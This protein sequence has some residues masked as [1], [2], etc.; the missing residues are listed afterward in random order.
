MDISTLG[1]CP[2]FAEALA[3]LGKPGWLPARVVQEDKHA[4]TAVGADGDFAGVIPGRLLH[5]SSSPADLPKVGD[6]VAVSPLPGERKAV[7]EAVL[8]R[9]SKLA[10]KVTGRET[11]EQIV[12]VNVD[13]VFVV[14]ALDASFNLRRL[15][16]F[17]VMV[18]EGGARPV[19]VLNKAD[20]CEQTEKQA[21]EARRAAGGVDL[22]TVSAKTRRGI[23]QLREYLRPGET[24]C[25]VGSSGV[26]KSSL[27]NR[28]H[29]GEAVQATLEVRE[30]DAKG[31]HATTWREIIPLPGGALVVDTPGMREFHLWQVEEGLQGTFPDVAELAL[32]CHFRDCTHEHEQHCAVK[33]AVDSGTLARD[34]YGSFLKLQ[35]E[36]VEVR[37]DETQHVR[38]LQ[39]K[40]DHLSRIKHG[41]EDDDGEE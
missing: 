36:R 41:Y 19:V 17:L 26:G 16:R 24:V 5:R 38:K 18:N 37:R 15:E 34:R 31:R 39:H 33:Q 22:L 3:A 14:Q 20:L 23:G 27:I 8:P 12:A 4:V 9:R 7:I 32:G 30:R 25:F 10:R 28:L 1:W 35:R 11:E 2:H 21:E 29:G 40:K 6:W 13:T